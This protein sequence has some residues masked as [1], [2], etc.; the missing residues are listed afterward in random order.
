M[1]KKLFYIIIDSETT[2]P[3]AKTN[4]PAKVADFSA[5]IVDK[6]GEIY[7]KCA[8]LVK[9]IY[10]N[11]ETPLYYS[12]ADTSGIWS[13][14]GQDIRYKRY[15]EMLNSGSRM[16]ASVNAINRWLSQ[17]VGKYNPILTAYNLAFDIDKC[18]NSGI[19]LTGFKNS[20]CLWYAAQAK[21]GHTKNYKQF[22]LDTHSFRPR[23]ELGNMSY[24]TNAE[25]MARFVLGNPELPDE[26]HTALEDVIYYELPI[27]IKLVNS[28]K[29]EFYLNPPAYNWHDYQVKDHFKPK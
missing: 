12:S 19:D 11:V 21:W 9:G 10:D 29:K 28:T 15:N 24:I 3:N 27:L 22:I 20:F 14:A 13:K 6:K 8:V 2:Q 16:L 17:A 26:P 23:T 25:I 5:V 1:A 7:N 18:N 4:L